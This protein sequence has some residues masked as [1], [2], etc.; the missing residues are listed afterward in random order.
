M[1]IAEKLQTTIVEL[2]AMTADAELALGYSHNERFLIPDDEVQPNVYS[3]SSTSAATLNSRDPTP[4]Y[5]A[6]PS[7]TIRGITYIPH[8]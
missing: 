4:A 6:A 2:I 1:S 5:E 8:Q 3:E 7:K